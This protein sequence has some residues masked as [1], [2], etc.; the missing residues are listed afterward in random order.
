MGRKK[1][2]KQPNVGLKNLGKYIVLKTT[3]LTKGVKSTKAFNCF[4]SHWMYPIYTGVQTHIYE[5]DNSKVYMYTYW[6]K[7]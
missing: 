6:K 7:I 3:K 4:T 2:S 1:T 5:Y